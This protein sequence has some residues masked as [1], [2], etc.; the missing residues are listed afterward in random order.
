MPVLGIRLVT[1]PMFRNTWAASSVMIP[2]DGQG[3]EFVPGV[4]GQPITPQDKQGEQDQDDGRSNEAQLLH[5]TTM[6]KTK[7]F[8]GSGM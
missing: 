1:T 8:S 5:S 6:E 3:A 4:E 2:H 7:S